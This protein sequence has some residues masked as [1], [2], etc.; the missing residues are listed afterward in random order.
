MID[1]FGKLHKFYRG[2]GSAERQLENTIG[3]SICISGCGKCCQANTVRCMTI[4]AMNAV[5]ILTGTGELTK[6]MSIAE[7]WLLERHHE[8]PT[9][10]GM[11]SGRFVPAK[12]KEE[13]GVL[14]SL[15]C[16]FLSETKQ[17]LIHGARPLVCRAY[18]VT[19]ITTG[20]CPRPPGKGETWS[21]YMYMQAPQLQTDIHKFKESYRVT[22]PEWVIFGFLPAVLYRAGREEKFR[23][24]VRDNR[25]ASAKI[26]GTHLDE[27]LMWQP[28]VEAIKKG[29]SPDMVANM[30]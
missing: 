10:E 20:F 30:V 29:V 22:H 25:I 3:R 21:E 19:R 27:T 2:F 15:P 9:Y 4:E 7:G 8:A 28:L 23:K 6:V 5:S 18:G 13:A 12:I 11:I 26:I 14:A 1:A 17:C 16:P 24:L